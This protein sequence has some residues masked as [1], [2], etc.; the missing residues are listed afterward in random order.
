MGTGEASS[1]ISLKRWFYRNARLP[2]FLSLLAFLAVEILLLLVIGKNQWE[3]QLE[4]SFRFAELAKIALIQKSSSV[5]QAGIDIAAR[6]LRAHKAFVCEK[7]NDCFLEPRWGF[8]VL[9]IPIELKDSERRNFS[10]VLQVPLFPKGSLIYFTVFWSIVACLLVVFL[11]GHVRSRLEKD[12][13][14]PLFKNLSHQAVLPIRELENIR[15][16]IQELN[17]LRTQEAVSQAVVA[18]SRQVAHDIK[19]PLTALLFASRD[20]DLLP[21]KSRNVIQSAVR[22]IE[23]IADSLLGGEQKESLNELLSLHPC[24]EE[25]FEEKKLE[26]RSQAGL[27]WKLDLKELDPI[28]E[29]PLSGKEIQRL[30]SNLINNAVEASEGAQGVIEVGG[31]TRKGFFEVWVRDE[32]KGILPELLPVLG[33]EGATYGK[34][35]GQGLGL[36]YAKHVLA[37][38]GGELTLTRNYPAGTLV[39]AS[40]PLK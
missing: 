22:R 34:Q 13:F 2:L 1:R 16:K 40:L 21:N 23:S 15:I 27:M 17:Q 7:K 11:L 14:A 12:L 35:K 10:L 3:H 37:K 30:L 39:K 9:E 36:S 32:G 26:Y 33:T 8:R 25:I 24:I 29:S 18:R 5:L 19:S 28:I 38:V 20:F 31:G 6:D 4:V